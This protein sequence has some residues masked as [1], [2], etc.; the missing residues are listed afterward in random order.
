[1]ISSVSPLWKQLLGAALG[2][3]IALVLYSAYQFVAPYAQGVIVSI[4]PE[5]AAA[6][7]T[8]KQQTEKQD[9]IAELAKERF[10]EMIGSGDL[11]E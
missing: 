5:Q 1:M 4:L 9:Q 10:R 3:V 11:A 7:Y 2:A 6:T 8:E